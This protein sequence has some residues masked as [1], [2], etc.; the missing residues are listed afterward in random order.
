MTRSCA[1]SAHNRS[2]PERL[3]TPKHRELAAEIG[4]KPKK[5]RHRVKAISRPVPALRGRG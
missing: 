2:L 1:V 3:D 4:F 5:P